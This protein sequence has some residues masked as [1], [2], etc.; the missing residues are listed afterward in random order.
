MGSIA[1]RIGV[2]GW[3]AGASLAQAADPGD[4]VVNEVMANPSEPGDD[5]DEFIELINISDSAVDLTDWTFSDGDAT[6]VL[7]PWDEAT[8]GDIADPDPLF[9]TSVIPAGGYA[10]ILD[11]EYEEG[12]QPYDFP[13]QTV[14]L[15]VKNTTVGDGLGS[16]DPI[17]LYDQGEILISTYGTPSDPE[18]GIPLNPGGG[19][20]AERTHPTRADLEGSWAE[21]EEEN[22]TPGAQNS[23]FDAGLYVVLSSFTAT[24]E[25]DRV[26]LRWETGTELDL[27]GFNV[28][29]GEQGG[30]VHR[31]NPD[32]LFATGDT[33]SGGAYVYAD[34]SVAAG[35]T[36]L[37][38]LESV[39]TDGRAEFVGEVIEIGLPSAMCVDDVEEAGPEQYCL[40]PSFPNPF[41]ASTTIRFQ[42]PNRVEV[43]VR[44][45]DVRGRPVRRIVEGERQAGRYEIP[46]DGRDED[47]RAVGSGVYFVRLSTARWGAVEKLTM[48]K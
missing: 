27:L 34:D 29:R 31:I 13:P 21:S 25:G 37:Y 2:A 39:H 41:N 24:Y 8:H 17:S 36:Y 46:W 20:S 28:H 26:V 44:I 9:S 6:D 43:I 42:V 23:A 4:L 1:L 14:L 40:H 45:Y 19:R 32:V 33:A 35:T 7:I 22:G 15:T 10:V 3:L 38:R 47:G 48:V 12:S 30:E 5:H 11:P 18:D 16:S